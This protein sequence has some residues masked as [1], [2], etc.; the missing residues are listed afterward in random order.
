MSALEAFGVL[1]MVAFYRFTR[2]L[3]IVGNRL[4]RSALNK[5]QSAWTT[6]GDACA[7]WLDP[8]DPA[9]YSVA[10]FI[11]ATPVSI[12]LTKGATKGQ[13]R[14]VRRIMSGSVL[15]TFGPEVEMVCRRA[16]SVGAPATIDLSGTVVTR[17]SDG[18]RPQSLDF[19]VQIGPGTP[20]C[21]LTHRTP[22]GED[23]VHTY[24][25][26][27]LTFRGILR[28]FLGGGICQEAAE[29][30]GLR[31]PRGRFVKRVLCD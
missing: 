13:L 28:P 19:R 24:M 14:L 12:T 7:V 15:H 21:T 8:R 11:N 5:I 17:P 29:V 18:S 4:R 1:C 6:L 25:A 26:V 22:G 20:M 27:V 31:E 9:G 3:K 30:L 23:C 16:A 10:E 2:L